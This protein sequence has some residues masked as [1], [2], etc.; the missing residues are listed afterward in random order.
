MADSLEGLSQRS[1]YEIE[2]AFG[3]ASFGFDPIAQVFDELGMEYRNAL[4]FTP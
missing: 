1:F 3:C 2:Q 4:S